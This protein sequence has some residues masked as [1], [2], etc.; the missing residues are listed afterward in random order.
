MISVIIFDFADYVFVN[1]CYDILIK[2]YI[3]VSDNKL[4]IIILNIYF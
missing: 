1:N 3:L 4:Y 2:N